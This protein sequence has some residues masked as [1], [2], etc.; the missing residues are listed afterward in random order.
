MEVHISVTPEIIAKNKLIKSIKGM[1]GCCEV[2]KNE[3][4]KELA[5]ETGVLFEKFQRPVENKYLDDSIKKVYATLGI[6]LPD[7][8]ATDRL[9]NNG[10]AILMLDTA[11]W[12]AEQ[13][14]Q[15]LREQIRAE[16]SHHQG[17]PKE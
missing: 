17:N 1:A 15:R 6:P 2:L 16:M 14:C 9:M 5:A 12:Y 10:E 3:L 11:I 13:Y 8:L 4:F 7:H